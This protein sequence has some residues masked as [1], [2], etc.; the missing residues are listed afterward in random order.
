[1]T[2]QQRRHCKHTDLRRD[3]IGQ[4]GGQAIAK[5]SKSIFRICT[6]RTLAPGSLVIGKRLNDGSEEFLVRN[7]WGDTCGNVTAWPC[8]GNGDFW[9]DANQLAA[10]TWMLTYIPGK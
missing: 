3:K 8:D 5:R 6:L 10:N 7:S 9:I 1:M 4:S 2:L